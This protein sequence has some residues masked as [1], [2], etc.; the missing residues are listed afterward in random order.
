MKHW[1]YKLTALVISLCII[2]L[3]Y[4]HFSVLHRSKYRFQE[5]SNRQTVDAPVRFRG[6][7]EQA[8][9]EHTGRNIV[10]DDSKTKIVYNRVGKC[11]SRS[12]L[13][14]ISELS[15]VNRFTFLNSPISNHS[16]ASIRDLMYIAHKIDNM[17]SPGIYTRHIHYLDFAKYGAQHPIYINLIRDPIKRFASH[18]HFLRFGDNQSKNGRSYY[19]NEKDKEMDI[20]E[21]VLTNH[22]LCSATKLYYIVPY[23]CGQDIM[24]QSPG[25][26]S[27]RRA[28]R[29][30]LE[31]YFVVGY[32]EDF[33]G[34]LEV[35]ESLL[36]RYF[37][38]AYDL[39]QRMSAK[40]LSDTSTIKKS[41]INDT[42]RKVLRERM[43]EEYEFYNFVRLRFKI[44]KKQFIVTDYS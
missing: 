14:L 25:E 17:P 13:S 41:Y 27:L 6:H 4:T 21:C 35:L 10:F 2:T 33:E 24:C 29:H 36:P 5:T 39:W 20:N 32:L 22:E 31:N 9:T 26:E 3:L 12:M 1:L 7:Q 38:G 19:M 40:M 18:Y 11:G 44:I 23:F 43:K 37:Y 15:R 28:K 30:V 42:A 16:Q 8:L 34:M